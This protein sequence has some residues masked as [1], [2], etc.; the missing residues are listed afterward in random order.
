MD[1]ITLAVDKVE[2]LLGHSPHPAIVTVPLGAWTV[3]NVCDGLALATGDDRYDDAAS[4]SMAIGLI[5]AA[6]AVVTGLRDYSHIPK[7]RPSHEIA[8]THGLGNAVVG[9]LMAASYILRTRDRAAGRPTGVTARLLGLTGGCLSLYTAWLGGKLVEEMGEG[10]QPVMDQQQEQE[11]L[12]GEE[13]PHGR[14]RLSP[15]SPLGHAH[16]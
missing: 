1:P 7:D 3:S 16:G 2:E 14:E 4:I 8:T 5:G 12:E 15:E 6:G 13:H 11:A 9:S 10:V